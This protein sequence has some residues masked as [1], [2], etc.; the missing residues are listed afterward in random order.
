[1]VNNNILDKGIYLDTTS[2]NHQGGDN[3]TINCGVSIDDDGT[4]NTVTAKDV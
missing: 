3:I 1:M 2:S 4:G